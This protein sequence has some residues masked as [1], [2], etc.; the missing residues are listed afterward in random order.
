MKILVHACCGPCLI[1]PADQLR[2]Q[3][4][5]LTVFYYNPNIHP[6]AE[7]EKRRATLHEYCQR[8]GLPVI[9]GTYN[10]DDYFQAV[11]SPQ[12][13]RCRL[14][15]QV[16]LAETAR[17]AAAG[18]FDAFTTT[19]LVSPYQKHDE[20]RQAGED[21]AADAGVSFLYEDWR[22]GYRSGQARARELDMY[23]QKYCG[24]VY[25]KEESRAA[26]R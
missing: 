23:R 13:D 20:L 21:A 18:G 2:R 14:C 9:D 16:R 8:V 1:Y 15:Y 6:L 7:F 19:L 17:R 24:C 4:L 11:V 25:S 12:V 26:N 22:A 10:I 5:D 3:G